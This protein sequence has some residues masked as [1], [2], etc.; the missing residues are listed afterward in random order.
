MTVL[1]FSYGIIMDRSINAPD[2]GNNYFFGFNATDKYYLKEQMELIGKLVINDTSR[3]GILPSASKDVSIKF[4]DKC[5]HIINN[6][7]MLTGLKGSTK[8]QKR[9]SICKYQ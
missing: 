1:W 9:E 2:H 6:K 3:I 5:I 8:M 4:V 7:D